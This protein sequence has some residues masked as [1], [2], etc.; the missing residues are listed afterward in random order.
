[1]DL[2]S[3]IT[4]ILSGA[5]ATAEVADAALAIRDFNATAVELAKLN[6][7]LLD[8]QQQL[9]TY[10]GDVLTLQAHNRE[11]AEQVKHLAA[12]LAERGRYDLFELGA[13]EF[14]YRSIKAKPEHYLCQVCFDGGVKS[15][16]QKRGRWYCPACNNAFGPSSSD[17]V[18]VVRSRRR[19]DGY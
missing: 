8:A 1:M 7:Q 17:A 11:L 3:S 5:K 13:G 15:V 10:G 19:W 12:Q 6:R 2:I 18:M 14:V 9:L 4:G 16:L